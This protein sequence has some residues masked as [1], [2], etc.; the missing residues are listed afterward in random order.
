[1]GEVIR[2]RVCAEVE[3]Q[4]VVF[5]IGM[6]INKVWKVWKWLPVFL[7]MPKMIRELYEHPELGMLAARGHFGLRNISVLQYWKSAK[8]LIDYA[9]AK[10]Q[11]HLPAWQ[12]F[13]Q[14]IGSNGDVGIWHETYVA[15][16][17][18]VE[19]LYVNMPRYGLGTFGNVFPAK[20]GRSTATKRLSGMRG[21]EGRAES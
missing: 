15:S 17:G 9:H 3:D 1:M 14:R 18:N 16:K 10:N 12:A 21:E 11:V 19:S 5:L 2:E 6:R 13:N 8:H 7:A 4:V 20:G